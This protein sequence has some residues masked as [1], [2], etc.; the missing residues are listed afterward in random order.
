MSLSTN[1]KWPCQGDFRLFRVP[2]NSVNK[3]FDSRRRPA[4]TPAPQ[5][6]IG[7]RGRLGGVASS[8]FFDIVVF[9]EGIRGRRFSDLWFGFALGGTGSWGAVRVFFGFMGRAGPFWGLL[10][11]EGICHVS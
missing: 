8:S 3:G 4:Y 6:G 11:L 1:G 10:A 9:L 2:G 7:T 5:R